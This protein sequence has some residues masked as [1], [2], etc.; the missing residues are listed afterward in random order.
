[1]VFA[2]VFHLS[3]TS[4]HAF[5]VQTYKIGT[6]IVES[7]DVLMVTLDLS[8]IGYN[9][10]YGSDYQ[11]SVYVDC[12]PC[13]ARYYCNYALEVPTCDNHPTKDEQEENFQKCL[14]LYKQKS[15]M[16]ANGTRADCELN[17]GQCESHCRCE[18]FPNA[19]IVYFQ[20]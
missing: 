18:T 5:A 13:P 14:N 8:G 10:T 2:S 20:R 1:M 12:K 3:V 4:A 6:I 7:F 9:L 15:C 11:I 16:M 19:L 17:A